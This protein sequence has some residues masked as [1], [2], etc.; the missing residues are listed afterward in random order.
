MSILEMKNDINIGP[1]G[2]DQGRCY[3]EESLVETIKKQPWARILAATKPDIMNSLK[4][5]RRCP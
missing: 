1:L 4:L 2:E 5:V 3:N